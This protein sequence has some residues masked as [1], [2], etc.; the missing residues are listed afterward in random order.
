MKLRITKKLVIQ[1]RELIDQD[2][3]DIGAKKK[4]PK[5]AKNNKTTIKDRE[6][7]LWSLERSTKSLSKF[8]E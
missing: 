1:L 2:T 8:K 3:S 4:E 6:A 5:I 7:L